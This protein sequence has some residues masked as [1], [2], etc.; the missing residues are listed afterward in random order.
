MPSFRKTYQL[1]IVL[2]I[3]LSAQSLKAQDCPILTLPLNGSTD[4]EITS[5]ISWNA[6]PGVTAYIISIGTTPGGTE[7]LNG[8]N[9]GSATTYNPI[10]GL[11]DNTQVYVTISLFI[12]GNV[13]NI[14]CASE[15][16]R[17]VNVTVPPD[18]TTFTSPLDGAT[19]VSVGTNIDWNYATFATGYFISMGTT[20]NGTDIANKIDALNNLS[21]NPPSDLPPNT[22]IFVRVTPY[23]ENNPNPT[24]DEI[25]FTTEE[26]A[27]LPLCTSLI[28]PAN[29][30]INVPLTPRIEWNAV[31]DATG[32][33]VSIGNSPVDPN[34]LDNASFST[35]ATTVID[36][37]PS[38]S[39]FITIIPFNAT[40]DALGC[41]QESFSTIPG[42][43]PYIDEST[44]AVSFLNPE[45][46]VPDVIEI[47]LDANSATYTSPDIAE[48]YR[49]TNIRRGSIISTTAEVT[50]SEPGEYRYE[51]FN[52]FSVAD[53]FIECPTEK[54]VTILASEAPRID[55]IKVSD[56]ALGLTLE[57]LVTGSGSY[58]Y[59]LDDINGP[60]QEDNRFTEVSPGD[61]TI[62]VKDKNGCGIAE[63]TTENELNPDS[64][65][66]FFTPNGDG[67]NDFW[68]YIP[69]LDRGKLNV[70]TIFIFDRFGRLLTQIDPTSDGW[71][72]LQNGR[73]V[74]E[75]DYWFTAVSTENQNI[76]GHFTLKR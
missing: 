76:S 51:V 29:G 68:Q 3:L 17:T 11:P 69:L 64:F 59:A 25:S 9:V 6:V 55:E 34:I 71:N 32:Y 75:S 63:R 35:N 13:T 33:R 1:I 23:N 56:T 36:F 72:G 52:V 40:G 38:T 14:S 22:T 10:L 27:P 20:P 18:C 50:F 42:C 67:I 12:F 48:G 15:T 47:C 7:I 5:A 41:I 39:F 46:G 8:L 61:H 24:C 60:Y 30:A 70:S 62:F 74:P 31:P 26:L 37:E 4:I 57:A 44:G 2:G 66:K 28:S 21:Y 43:G 19:D 53:I 45:T 49:W 58:E 65:P 16:F 73:P 54:N